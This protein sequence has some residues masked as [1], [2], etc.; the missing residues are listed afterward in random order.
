[1][2]AVIHAVER[3]EIF[4]EPLEDDLDGF[5]KIKVDRHRLILQSEA[6][7]SGPLFKIV[8]AERRQVVY[9]LFSQIMGVE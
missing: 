1:M 3:G 7:S 9:E 2:R 6:G 8:F 5:Y 4:P